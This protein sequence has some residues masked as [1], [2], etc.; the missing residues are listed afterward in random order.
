RRALFQ[1][2]DQQP[3]MVNELAHPHQTGFVGLWTYL[4]AYF[5]NLRISDT[6]CDALISGKFED[7][8][9]SVDGTITRW[10]LEG[11]GVVETESTGILNLNR[12][13]PISVNEAKLRLKIEMPKDGRLVFHVVF[14]DVLTLQID[15]I[16]LFQGENI[17]HNSPAWGER[18]YVSMTQRID[19]ALKKGI[20]TLTAVLQRTE[21][22]GFGIMAA[23]EGDDY[24][25]LPV[26]L[27]Q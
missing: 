7:K 25:L 9:Q 17:F 12:Y 18:G 20:H 16:P 2:G 19:C 1:V 5:S 15:D 11:F 27:S 23:I 22:F 24:S 13:L 10:F 14:S 3:L 21:Y 8:M 6:V 26:Q 4:P